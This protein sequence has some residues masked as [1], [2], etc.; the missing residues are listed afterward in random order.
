IDL[1][2][3]QNYTA[4]AHTMAH[5]IRE[6]LYRQIFSPVRWYQSLQY[7]AEQGVDTFVEI[8]PK[9]VLSKLVVQ[10]LPHARVMNVEKVEDVEKVIKTLR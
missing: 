2:L 8:G 3:V 5:E 1:P 9:N 10:T 7:M 4:K 6:N